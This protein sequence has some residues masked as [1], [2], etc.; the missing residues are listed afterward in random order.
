MKL[1]LHYWNFSIPSESVPIAPTLAATA[2][3]AEQ[4]GVSSF[5]ARVAGDRGDVPLPVT[6]PALAD[7]DAFVAEVAE[8][9]ALGTTEVQIMPDR[10]PVEFAEQVA[11]QV[12]S[13]HICVPWSVVAA[14]RA[15]AIRAQP[16]AGSPGVPAAPRPV[17][18][19][20]RRPRPRWPGL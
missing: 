8:Y 11:E 2:R 3:V 19:A 18:R 14:P 1:G 12:L 16:L 15:A 17:Q 20:P 5:T 10:H 6:R 13:R 4:A 9:A 7:V